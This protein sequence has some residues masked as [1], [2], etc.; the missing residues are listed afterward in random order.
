MPL[1]TVRHQSIFDPNEYRNQKI[2]II[3]AGA[4][5]SRVFA[6]LID[7]GIE[8]IDVYDFDKVEPH[9]LANQIYLSK[10]ISLP[11]VEALS[12]YYSIKT[13]GN[14]PDT[15]RFFNKKVTGSDSIEPF[16]FLYLL[17]DTM[18]SRKTISESIF[19]TIDESTVGPIAIVETRMGPNYGEL[20]YFDPW[21]KKD[22]QEWVNTLFDDDDHPDVVS[23]CGTSISVGPTANLIAN[24]AVWQMINM[25]QNNKFTLPP[26]QLFTNPSVAVIG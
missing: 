8:N 21:E 18:S 16:S 4:T 6:S 14:P 17:T 9:N 2:T 7:L 23:P 25:L 26:Q 12:D 22:R 3:G 11:K 20:Y 10:H 15:M 13:G 19:K 1:S 5:G 24:H